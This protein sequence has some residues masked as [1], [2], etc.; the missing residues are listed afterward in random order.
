MIAEMKKEIKKQ[1]RE[2]TDPFMFFGGRGY[3]TLFTPMFIKTPEGQRIVENCLTWA[4]KKLF[5]CGAA[6][7][8]IPEGEYM[9]Q[10]VNYIS[11]YKEFR[12]RAIEKQNDNTRWFGLRRK[13]LDG[14]NERRFVM[15]ISPNA[16]IEMRPAKYRLLK[17]ALEK[18]FGCNL[19]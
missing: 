6:F 2:D 14:E 9:L 8:H 3:G 7:Y 10:P 11:S 19:S 18:F 16:Y 17:K 1:D 12:D 4:V 5:L 15:P 13:P